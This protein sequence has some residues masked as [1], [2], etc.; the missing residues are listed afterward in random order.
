VNKADKLCWE[1]ALKAC[2]SACV[3]VP[4]ETELL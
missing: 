2:R 4:W 3:L 1:Q